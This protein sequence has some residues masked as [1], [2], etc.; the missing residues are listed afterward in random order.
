[1][2]V[3]LSFYYMTH[4]SAQNGV[5]VEKVTTNLLSC[6]ERCKFQTAT[7]FIPKTGLFKKEFGDQRESIFANLVAIFEDN[8]CI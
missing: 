8:H 1:M 3:K 4:D 7:Y 6:K 5:Q 2:F